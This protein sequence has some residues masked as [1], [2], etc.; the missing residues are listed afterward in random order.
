MLKQFDRRRRNGRIAR[1]RASAR[2]CSLRSTTKTPRCTSAFPMRSMRSSPI[3]IRT[4]RQ[5]TETA[6]RA[7]R[8]GRRFLFQ[9]LSFCFKPCQ[10]FVSPLSSFFSLFQGLS[11]HF[12]CSPHTYCV[13]IHS[14]PSH[15]KAERITKAD[16]YRFYSFCKAYPSL[17]HSSSGKA[18]PQ[19]TTLF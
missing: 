12:A 7:P 14:S 10:P 3:W 8:F 2:T 18:L 13:F 6:A 16:P 4:N 9:A 15:G 17:F 5:I 19:K 11:I 1:W